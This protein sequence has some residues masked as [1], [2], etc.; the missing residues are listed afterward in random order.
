[1]DPGAK[2]LF[3]KLTWQFH[4]AKRL[5]SG[6]KPRKVERPKKKK[7]EK[8]QDGR[9]KSGPNSGN[10]YQMEDNKAAP[11]GAA[12]RDAP[13]DS[14]CLRFGKD[15]LCFG[16]ISGALLDLHGPLQEIPWHCRL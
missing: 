1:M 7:V 16:Y 12:L 3:F 8:P 2:R 5:F 11:K 14:C 13:L 15:F 10:P 9:Q 4:G 6:A